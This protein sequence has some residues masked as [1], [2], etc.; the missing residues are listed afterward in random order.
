M[1]KFFTFILI[2]LL[3]SAC[4]QP[5]E[6]S[7]SNLPQNMKI[8]SPGFENNQS[9]PA[10]FTCQGKNVSP[11]LQITGTPAEAK[12]LTLIVDD[13]DAPMGVWTHWVVWNI[14]ANTTFIIENSAP[15]FSTQGVTSFGKNE[16]GGPCPPSGTHRYFFKI[17]AL[18]TELTIPASSNKNDL[19]NAIKDHILDS[20]ELIGKYQKS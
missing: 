13:P 10:K 9:I 6:L 18:D 4:S 5:A 20:A 3:L 8:S 12:S 7:T 2:S 19:L 16:Y 15:S 17:Y 1:K 11:E 14:P